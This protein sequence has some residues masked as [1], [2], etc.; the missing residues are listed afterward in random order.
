[1]NII[2]KARICEP[3]IP[4][5]ALEL[6]LRAIQGEIGEVCTRDAALHE[7]ALSGRQ[8]RKETRDL[9]SEMKDIE[10][11][12]LN[13]LSWDRRIEGINVLAEEHPGPTMPAGILDVTSA[14]EASHEISREVHPS[15]DAVED[16]LLDVAELR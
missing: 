6:G 16:P 2:D 1:V 5:L 8:S 13:M 14:L 3:L 12:A 10:E 4:H 7:L 11:N 15:Q 9:R